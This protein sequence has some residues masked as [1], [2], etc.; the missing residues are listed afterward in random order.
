V[1]PYQEYVTTAAVSL[2]E[3]RATLYQE[4]QEIEKC[5]SLLLILNTIENQLA[6]LWTQHFEEKI[7]DE[8]T[9]M[10]ANA[11]IIPQ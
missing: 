11:L 3:L 5:K 9:N 7:F 4:T 10:G 2:V 6:S 8:I 1:A